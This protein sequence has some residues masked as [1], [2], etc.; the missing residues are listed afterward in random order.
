[1]ALY[2][3]YKVV[4]T[5]TGDVLEEFSSEQ[6]AERFMMLLRSKYKKDV[7]VVTDKADAENE[8]FDIE[9]LEIEEP[10]PS[11][12]GSELDDIFGEDDPGY[13]IESGDPDIEISGFNP[14]FE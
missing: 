12:F 14:D 6:A 11:V 7:H 5:K 13:D 1:M 4:E 8:G 2:K 3:R 9:G 10:D